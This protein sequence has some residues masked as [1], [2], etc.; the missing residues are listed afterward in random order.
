M[1]HDGVLRSYRAGICGMCVAFL[2]FLARATDSGTEVLILSPPPGFVVDNEFL[3]VEFGV[4]HPD[5][6]AWRYCVA[7]N[8][9]TAVCG[10]LSSSFFLR[11]AF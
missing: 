5:A 1:A 3:S 11:S 7:V 2:A 4:A 10:A 6:A 9:V 8:G